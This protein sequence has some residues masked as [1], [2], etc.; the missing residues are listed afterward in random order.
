[1]TPLA[2]AKV[3]ALDYAIYLC[4]ARKSPLKTEAYNVALNEM[5]I[6]L[7][8]AKERVEMGGDMQSYAQTQ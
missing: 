7:E 1:M 6:F 8:A 3:E 2:K 5:K 4:N